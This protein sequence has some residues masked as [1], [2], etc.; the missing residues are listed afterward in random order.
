MVD[1][2]RNP[3]SLALSV[4]RWREAVPKTTADA[5]R[6]AEKDVGVDLGQETDHLLQLEAALDVPTHYT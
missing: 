4:R 6:L 1:E 3:T 5:R 2:S